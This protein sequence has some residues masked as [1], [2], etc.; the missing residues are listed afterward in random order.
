MAKELY[1]VT[2]E[3]GVVVWVSNDQ[4]KNGGETGTSF[5][6]ALYF[7]EIGFTIYDTM[8]YHKKNLFLTVLLYFIIFYYILL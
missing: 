6:M 1:R 4:V 7:Q 8:I 5:R 2:N 3:G